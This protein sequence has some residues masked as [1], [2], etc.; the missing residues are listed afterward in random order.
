MSSRTLA[1]RLMLTA[2]VGCAVLA[3]DVLLRRAFLSSFERRD[4]IVYALSAVA[5]G[6]FWASLFALAAW[7]PQ[8]AVRNVAL[9]GGALLAGLLVGGQLY[10][11]SRYGNYLDYRAAIVGT[12]MLPSVKQ[13]LWYDR[14][15]FARTVFAP[16]AVWL[17]LVTLARITLRNSVQSARTWVHGA[18][19]DAATL[20]LLVAF[21][22]PPEMGRDQGRVPDALYLSAV[23][24][25]IAAAAPQ[26]AAPAVLVP[27]PRTPTPVP[28]FTPR[29][30]RSVVFIVTESVRA[31]SACSRFEA[32]CETTPFTNRTL[33][34]RMGLTQMRALDST[35]ALSLAALWL[36]VEPNTPRDAFHRRPIVWDY[37]AAAGFDTAYFTSQ[38]LFFANSGT[39]LEG[40]PARLRVSGTE[41]DPDA[42]YETGADDELLVNHALDKIATMHAP[43]FAVVHL[44]NTHFPYRIGDDA[45]FETNKKYDAREEQLN[46]Y[47]D[48]IY[49][50]DAFVAK[51]ASGVR[52]MT[53]GQDVGIV[54]VSD[55]GEQLKEKGAVGH[56]G[57]IF[58]V[59]V[60]VPFWLDAP[61][62]AD[63][64]A[65][66]RTLE[67][68][69][70]AQVDVLPTV[71]DV[72][73]LWREPALAPFRDGFAG[74]S[75][76]L[77]GSPTRMWTLT[78]CSPF[79]TCAF[80][81]WGAM[82]GSKKILAHQGDRDWQCFDVADDPREEKDLGS[83]ACADLRTYIE[84]A[85]PGKP[86]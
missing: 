26:G 63:A 20:G 21:M 52:A 24:Q 28:R 81:N 3:C 47:E 85:I 7:H 79:W 38:N 68:R 44:S 16:P 61:V 51:L 71:L 49:R 9:G 54:F 45:P 82:R 56:T 70:L 40:I 10:L 62:S 69:P 34:Q 39:W 59:E 1:C 55:H 64:R 53:G 37:A 83:N 8:R 23:G 57:T 73:G 76:L 74:E 5:C 84:A 32:A 29:A 2:I 19:A 25:V 77:G 4:A 13:Q 33:P 27:G 15:T 42:S 12:G 31:L 75:L 35:T 43:Y 17:G 6:M 66:M 48:S 14:A 18:L 30:P 41:I 78:N 60:R 11:F 22:A 46:R 65:T 86:F 50:Q 80:K 72:M 58:D 67:E 36:G